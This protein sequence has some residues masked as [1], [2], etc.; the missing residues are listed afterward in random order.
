MEKTQARIYLFVGLI[1]LA[2]VL[3]YVQSKVQ[4][5]LIEQSDVSITEEV[6]NTFSFLDETSIPVVPIVDSS[7]PYL[8][9]VAEYPKGI[10]GDSEIQSIVENGISQ[11]KK[12]YT[13][14][15]LDEF[16]PTAESQY[17][18][19][20]DYH[21][22][23]SLKFVTHILE[24]FTYTGGAHGG[25]DVQTYSFDIDGNEIFLQDMFSEP[26]GLAQ[27]S[28]KIQSILSTEEYKDLVNIEWLEEGAGPN[29]QNFSAFTFNSGGIDFIFQQ[30]QVGPYV[31]GIIEVP[32]SFVE[33]KDIFK[34]EYLK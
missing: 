1:I 16:S 9:I 10:V 23:H 7:I 8:D 30:Y 25:T 24:V 5:Q 33:L 31:S 26:D 34:P 18:L 3:V 17:T 13:F 12:E 14:Y 29:V 32:L 2:G 11:F 4:P 21:T 28:K 19:S 22:T 15:V 20:V 27:L 6:E